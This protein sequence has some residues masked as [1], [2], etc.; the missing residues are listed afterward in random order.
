[1]YM[2]RG[3]MEEPEGTSRSLWEWDLWKKG[4]QIG[5]KTGTSSDFV[6]GWYMGLT[7]DLVTGVWVGCDERTVHFRSSGTGEG[8]HTALP[9]FGKFMEKVYHDPTTGYTYGPFPPPGV[10]ITREYNCTTPEPVVDTTAIDS[11]LVD[12]IPEPD[13]TSLEKPEDEN[14][15]QPQPQ[16]TAPAQQP[17]NQTPEQTEQEPAADRK[18]RREQAREARRQKREQQQNN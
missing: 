8:A 2:F 15:P 9:I 3:G 5:G 11:T 14:I 12:S 4:N 1:M 13:T 10:E 16:Q 17:E 18:T 7:K 6:D